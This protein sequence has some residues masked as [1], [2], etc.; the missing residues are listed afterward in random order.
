MCRRYCGKNHARKSSFLFSEEDSILRLEKNT[1]KK[2]NC[3]LACAENDMHFE[4]NVVYYVWVQ[5]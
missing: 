3:I 2:F 5:V 1:A 4:T